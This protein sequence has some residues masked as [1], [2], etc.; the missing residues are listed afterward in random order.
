MIFVIF[1]SYRKNEYHIYNPKLKSNRLTNHNF[2][3]TVFR[4]LLKQLLYGA[5]T[6]F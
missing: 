6:Q 2:T 1:F 4:I 3:S 5:I